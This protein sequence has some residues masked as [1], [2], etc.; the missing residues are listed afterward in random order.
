MDIASGNGGLTAGVVVIGRN[1][2]A[3]L[4]QCLESLR[5]FIRT[6]VYVDSGS[7]DDSV[8]Y[9][10]GIG[11]SVVE[12]DSSIPFTAARARNEGFSALL[13]AHPTLDYV[14][15]VDGDC[16]VTHGWLAKA[17]EFL[18]RNPH[19]A[20]VCGYRRERYPDRSIYNM[21]C[22]TEWRSPPPGETRACGGDAVM[23]VC[24]FQQVQ[25]FRSDLICGEEPELCIRLR[26]AGWQ[27]WRLD[28][29]MTVHD[30]AM[31]RFGQWWKRSLRSGY[32]CARGADLHGASPERY[33]VVESRRAWFWGLWL[34]ATIIL[35]S[36]VLTPLALGLVLL[37]PLQLVRL[38]M[39]GTFTTRENWWR[40]AA[41]VV[42]KFP[43]M[44][45]QAKYLCDRLTR[46]QSRL[47]EYK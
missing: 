22:D 15:F 31:H 8:A 25:G 6:T 35:L 3:R 20:I 30:A 34:P 21:L 2:G 9:C 36:A 42:G 41:L 5:E 19:V 24:A 7:T 29:P 32:G 44:L 43:E 37:Y 18:D 23:R 26:Q 12:L 46:V 33:C 45:G 16:E 10:R 28:E 27:I 17:G 39:S 11:I 1:E 40:A 14:F 4:R 47:I 13:Q 38:A